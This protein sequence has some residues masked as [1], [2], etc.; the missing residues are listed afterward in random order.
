MLAHGLGLH[1]LHASLDHVWRKG[2]K[3]RVIKRTGPW[4]GC[5]GVFSIVS[6]SIH[7]L[8][9]RGYLS[10]NDQYNKVWVCFNKYI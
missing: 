7:I 9:T 5:V 6:Y 3:A 4:Q 8:G 2:K 1:R 10:R